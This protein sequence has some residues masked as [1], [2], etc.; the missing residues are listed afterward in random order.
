[1]KPRALA[2]LHYPVLDRRG[3]LIASAVTNLDLHDLARAAMTFGWQRFYV[4]TPVAEQRR[5]AESIR[6]HW[7]RGFG[8][9]YNPHRKLALDLMEILPDLES[10]VAAWEDFAGEQTLPVLTGASVRGGI[11]FEQCRELNR[12]RPLLLLLGTG[13][14]LAPCL[15][16]KG[17]PALEPIRGAGEYNHLPVRSA[18]SIIMDRLGGGR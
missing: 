5:L 3:D 17:W 7:C 18:A 13:W 4:V 16:E 15:F 2:L 12:R 1:M 6:E 8:A 9:G 11:S 10:A 14:G